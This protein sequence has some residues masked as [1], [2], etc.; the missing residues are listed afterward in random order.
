MYDP[1]EET[2]SEIN[3]DGNIFCLAGRQVTQSRPVGYMYREAPNFSGDSG[4][5]FFTGSESDEYMRD[6][7]NYKICTLEEICIYNRD[8]KAFLHASRGAAFLRDKD[9]TFTVFGVGEPEPQTTGNTL[10]WKA[11]TGT[12]GSAQ[13]KAGKR[14]KEEICHAQAI[15][16]HCCEHIG[17]KYRVLRMPQ[18]DFLLLFPNRRHGFYTLVSMGMSARDMPVPKE[19]ETLGLSRAELLICLENNGPVEDE[20]YPGGR[21]DFVAPMLEKIALT[22]FNSGNWLGYGH[23]LPN[24]SPMRPYCGGTKLCGAILDTPRMFQSIFWNL[25]VEKQGKIHFYAVVPV[26]KEEIEMKARKGADEVLSR[27]EKRCG[28]LLNLQ[29]RNIARKF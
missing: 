16:R 29:R 3:V 17:D 9:N 19:F 22:P 15:V 10:W 21:L 18:M 7:R 13:R 23:T 12:P 4:W 25:P 8:I 11:S 5:R 20:L 24:G 1:G 14:E 28:T 26:Y 6:L 2:V 27:I